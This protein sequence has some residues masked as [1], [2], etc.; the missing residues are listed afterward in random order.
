V[1]VE[2]P[3]HPFFPGT[4]MQPDPDLLG[5]LTDAYL[6]ETAPAARAMTRFLFGEVPVELFD[7]IFASDAPES[8]P[9]G[10]YLWAFHLVAER[11]ALAGR[12]A[13]VANAC[14]GVW[15]TSYLVGITDGRPGRTL[16]QFTQE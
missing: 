7:R 8:L 10:G 4:V 1:T 11:D 13:A 15:L 16:P 14:M 2:L 3:D 9:T 12:R 6:A 5:Q